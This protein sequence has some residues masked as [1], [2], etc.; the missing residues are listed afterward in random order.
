M[1][2]SATQ[3]VINA[4]L[5]IEHLASTPEGLEQLNR[6]RLGVCS[7]ILDV[8][9]VQLDPEVEHTKE[10]EYAYHLWNHTYLGLFQ[11]WSEFSGHAAYPVVSEPFDHPG[12][13]DETLV[14]ASEQFNG[15]DIMYGHNP[16]GE[17][18][19][20]LVTYLREAYQKSL[21]PRVEYRTICDESNNP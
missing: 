1:T 8:L 16:Y 2:C 20:R 14:T 12:D 17:A 21:N 9:R 11:E 3:G 19:L 5:H 4:L 6:T 15:A 10:F 13:T 18:R 7:T